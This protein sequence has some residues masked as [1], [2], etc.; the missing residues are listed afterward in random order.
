[1]LMATWD[2][3]S[4][5]LIVATAKD[6]PAP[7]GSAHEIWL[8]PA[9]GKPMPVG[10]MPDSRMHMKLSDLIA[11]EMRRGATIAISIEPRGG[12]PTGSPTGPVV[13]SGTLENT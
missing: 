10:M 6:M 3:V 8:I 13:A 9:G 1:M 2:P 11:E 5:R 12:S 4:E 7:S